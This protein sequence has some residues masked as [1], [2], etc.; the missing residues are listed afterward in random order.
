MTARHKSI[1]ALLVIGLLVWS[2]FA[3]PI[4][5]YDWI[6]VKRVRDMA[7]EKIEKPYPSRT[8][9]E[10]I[11]LSTRIT[12]QTEAYIRARA[13]EP[14]P[15]PALAGLDFSS[16]TAYQNSTGPLRDLF[17]RTLCYPLSDAIHGSDF[18]GVQQIPVGED[19]FATYTLLAIPALPGVDAF[20]TLIEP[21]NHTGKMPLIIANHGRGSLPP[22]PPDGKFPMMMHNDRDL[23]RWA[24]ERGWAVFEPLFLFYGKGYPEY[25]R[26]I[27]TLRAQQSGI[28]MPAIEITKVERAIDYLS[29]RPELDTQRLAMVGVSYGGFYTLYITALDPRIRVAVVCAY[30][31]DRAQVLSDGEPYGF[32]DWRYPNSLS[33]FTDPH[34]VAMVCPRPLQIQSGNQDQ[35]FPIE[36]SRR[37]IP[38]AAAYYQK[39]HLESNF[40]FEEIIGRHDFNGGPA[41]QFID[42]AFQSTK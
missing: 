22:P 10:S 11:D 29:T 35:L 34:V 3:R 23:A 5:D 32:L 39:L 18:S 27:L 4:Y 15:N 19:D 38:E 13:S 12:A 2:Y 17:A 36:G 7:A 14:A 25:I 1:L 40:D 20:G 26:D 6:A 41:G 37:T 24:V 33:L 9:D 31:N 8:Y 42:Q 21:K 28:S 16:P 30:F